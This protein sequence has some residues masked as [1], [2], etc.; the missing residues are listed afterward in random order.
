MS[1]SHLIQKIGWKFGI[2]IRRFQKGLNFDYV[3]TTQLS[4]YGIDLVLDVGANVG[5]FVDRLRH[6]YEYDGKVIS[7][8]PML[9][10]RERLAARAAADG[11]WTVMDYGFGDAAGEHVLNVSEN[12]QSSSLLPMHGRHEE[13]APDS[14]YIRKETIKIETLNNVFPE[15]AAGAREIYLKIDVQGFEMRVLEGASAVLDKVRLVQ[16]E[17]SVSEMYESEALVEELIAYMRAR[18]FHLV[19]LEP[20]FTDPGSGALLQLDGLFCRF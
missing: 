3:Q 9:E 2:E 16:L 11:N 6:H 13:A 18:K 17:M 14:Q 19:G 7:F 10:A 1:L 15:L 4:R 12:L 8:E 20:N 5:Q